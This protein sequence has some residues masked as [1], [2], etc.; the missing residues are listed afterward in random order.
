MAR[1]AASPTHPQ[2]QKA[3]HFLDVKAL[4]NLVLR[5]GFDL[6]GKSKRINVRIPA[7]N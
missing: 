3:G 7:S 2:E 5:V 6:K 1:F 4:R